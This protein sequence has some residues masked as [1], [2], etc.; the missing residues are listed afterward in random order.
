MK[1]CFEGIGQLRHTL[2][3]LLMLLGLLLFGLPTE[4]QDMDCETDL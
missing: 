4:E 1:H 3:L 2:Q